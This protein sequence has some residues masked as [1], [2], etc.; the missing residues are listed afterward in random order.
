MSIISKIYLYLV[1]LV[2][3]LVI[4]CSNSKNDINKDKY[5]IIA[6]LIER[7]PAGPPPPPPPGVYLKDTIAFKRYADSVN[8]LDVSIVLL[9]HFIDS[10]KTSTQLK[11][12]VEKD[13]HLLIERLE[14]V[15]TDNSKINFDSIIVSK[16]RKI[17]PTNGVYRDLLK[18]N[19]ASH[20][21][22]FSN[23]IFSKNRDKAV[24]Y[25]INTRGPL[26]GSTSLVLL[27]KSDG[28]WKVYKN[29]GLTIS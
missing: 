15:E 10:E 18:D 12:K 25:I 7:L 29:I 24:I 2:L 6:L 21:I 8:R 5:E 13:F 28:K 23:I 27:Q 17:I 26:S 22:A 19:N 20:Y 14:N 1:C 16:N 9:D 3:L 4:S 11:R